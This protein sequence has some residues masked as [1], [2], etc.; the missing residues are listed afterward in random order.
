MFLF[1]FSD[2]VTNY[3]QDGT[4]TDGRHHQQGRPQTSRPPSQR[5]RGRG[6]Q[7]LNRPHVTDPIN[8]KQMLSKPKQVQKQQG[9]NQ[10]Q[11]QMLSNQ[12]QVQK[13]STN[14][15]P[16]RTKAPGADS[17]KTEVKRPVDQAQSNSQTPVE[18]NRT[19]SVQSAEAGKKNE[20]G[21]DRKVQD[22]PK[23][24]EKPLGKELGEEEGLRYVKFM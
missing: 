13:E 17:S 10:K 22:E 21:G 1:S 18:V 6:P 20:A 4:R 11:E 23:K 3:H 15:T 12:E 7:G 19:K 16:D 14:Q 9:T 2:S 24:K 5:G 8:K